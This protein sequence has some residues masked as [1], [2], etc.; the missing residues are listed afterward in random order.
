MPSLTTVTLARGWVFKYK[1]NAH[2]KSSLSLLSF[3]PRHHSRSSTVSRRIL[4]LLYHSLPSFLQT[5]FQQTP[6]S[7]FFTPILSIGKAKGRCGVFNTSAT[8][9]CRPSDSST[10]SHEDRFWTNRKNCGNI[11]TRKSLETKLQDGTDANSS[12]EGALPTSAL[13]TQFHALNNN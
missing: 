9:F 3:I 12:F 5:H 13:P 1:R 11:H 8:F 4:R 2:T 10:S 7:L 6:H